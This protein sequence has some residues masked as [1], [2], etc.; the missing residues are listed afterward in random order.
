VRRAATAFLIPD[1][2]ASRAG[3]SSGIRRVASAFRVGLDESVTVWFEPPYDASGERPH[4]VILMPDR[5]VVVMECLEVGRTRFRG[6]FGGLVRLTVDGVE[7]ERENPLARADE[8]ARALA[9]RVGAHPAKLDMPI[10][11]GATFPALSREDAVEIG[12]DRSMDLARCLFADE[13]AAGIAGNG[14][15]ALLRVMAAI[16]GGGS[17]IRPEHEPLV[18]ALIQPELVISESGRAD[19]PGQLSIFVPPPSGHDTIRVMDRRQEALAKGLGEGHRVVRG[20]AG[21]GKTLLLVYRARLVSRMMPAARILVTC[22]TRS[23]AGQLRDALADCPN[24]EARHLDAVMSDLI[25]EAGGVHPGYDDQSGTAVAEAALAAL[26][27][28]S[29]A[30]YRAVLV[31]EAQDFS[32]EAL[33]VCVTLV[34]EGGDLMVVADAAQNIF[35]RAFSWSDS[36]IQAQGRTRVLRVNYRNTREILRLASRVLGVQNGSP[37]D[38]APDLDDMAAI[39]PP[40]S[41]AR[42]GMAP[43]VEI[44][45]SVQEEVARTVAIAHRL[46]AEVRSPRSVAVLFAG[47]EEAGVRRADL[48]H[49]GLVEAGVDHIWLSDPRDRTRRDQL[50]ASV[51]PVVLS[52]IHSAKGLEF[53]DVVVC[54]LWS[55][56]EDMEGNRR[57]VYVGMTRA[58]DRLFVVTTRGN[59]FAA[60]LAGA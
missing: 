28:G 7:E 8:L 19:A 42:T 6:A 48:L 53:P 16:L 31:D 1:N 34:D 20:V 30:R 47:T 18:R 58:V 60:E 2:L 52:T 36:G 45:D 49:T 41:A 23:L 44:V 32:A 29:G 35:R 5:G 26:E 14:E 12:L 46:V 3:V 57:L 25:R 17:P 39:V 11:A 22:F 50:T 37:N 55:P 40:E 9:E 51:V 13:I 56:H 27:K 54:G 59:P 4:F 33:R 38:D 15:T 43:S 24:V 10:G 21:S